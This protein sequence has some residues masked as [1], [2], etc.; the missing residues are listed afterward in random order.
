MSRRVPLSLLLAAV[1]LLTSGCWDSLTLDQRAFVVMLG[2]D[3]TPDSRFRV[4]AQIQLAGHVTEG[5]NK[6]SA[7][8]VRRATGE[9]ST[10]QMAIAL[11]RGQ[12]AREL[13][14]TFCD[15]LVL[16]RS[17]VEDLTDVEWIVRSF[18][19][20]I[21]AYIAVAQ[22]D[23]AEVINAGARGFGVPAEFPLFGFSGQWTRT[24]EVVPARSWMVFNRNW[25]TPLED[26]YAPVLTVGEY[27]LTF[28]GLGVFNGRRLAGF[29]DKDQTT[30]FSLLMGLRSERAVEATVSRDPPAVASVYVHRTR[31][32]RKVT[33]KGDRPVIHIDLQAQGNLRELIGMRIGNARDQA[34]VEAALAQSLLEQVT[35]GMQQLQE[36]G[37][38]PVGFGEL[39]R[40]NAPYRR[41]VQSARAWHEAYQRAE[42]NI[43]T[44]VTVVAPGY[45]K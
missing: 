21:S 42:L 18:P 15:V 26:P 34:L 37:S 41:E 16:G 38:D 9:A 2:I 28:G 4:T 39:A 31:V 25:F 33:W 10:I 43:R 22:G 36:L 14:L 5:G 3:R 6:E 45:M 32:H 1:L 19:V 23:A 35:R 13:D 17:T 8:K 24:P 11:I 29:L 12:V 40:Q 7:P 30:V 44:R 27:G 20:P